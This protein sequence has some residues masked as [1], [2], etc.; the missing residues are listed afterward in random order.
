[1][2]RQRE[3]SE[4][5]VY[6]LKL[7]KQYT[8]YSTSA[9]GCSRKKYPVVIAW[10]ATDPRAHGHQFKDLHAAASYFNMSYHQIHK[11]ITREIPIEGSCLLI[12]KKFL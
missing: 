12:Y 5:P 10:H 1:M 4:A 7:R 6:Y 9:W 2:K 8:R 3:Q 11:C